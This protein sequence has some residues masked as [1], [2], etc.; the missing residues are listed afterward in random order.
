MKHDV[1]LEN[2]PFV[3]EK[4]RDVCHGRAKPES[5][6]VEPS[7]AGAGA[8]PLI[9]VGRIK[10]VSL[11]SYALNSVNSQNKLLCWA[12]IGCRNK[13]HLLLSYL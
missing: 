8:G 5:S 7:R 3:S 9:S 10:L 1:R 12:K 2:S 6:R 13:I 11:S 4:R